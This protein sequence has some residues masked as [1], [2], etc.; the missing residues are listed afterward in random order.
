MTVTTYAE[1]G[2][3]TQLTP[4]VFFPLAIHDN[5]IKKAARNTLILEYV[6]V[7]SL[8]LQTHLQFN[9]TASSVMIHHHLLVLDTY[10]YLHKILQ[11]NSKQKNLISVYNKVA[12]HCPFILWASPVTND[13]K[14]GTAI[15]AFAANHSQS[16]LLSS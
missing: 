1:G 9:Y 10:F 14:H 12:F 2:C 5:S 7:F 8:I 4:S 3:V 16:S 15:V 6:F 13:I 11:Y